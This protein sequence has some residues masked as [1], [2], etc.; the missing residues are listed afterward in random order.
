MQVLG[1]IFSERLEN[2]Y[3]DILKVFP[4]IQVDWE[5]TDLKQMAEKGI[6]TVAYGSFS[7]GRNGGNPKILL[8]ESGLNENTISHELLHLYFF[9]KG[10][11]LG[12]ADELLNDISKRIAPDMNNILHHVL[13]HN[14]QLECGLIIKE[15]LIE[16]MQRFYKSIPE[17]DC[18]EINVDWCRYIKNYIQSELIYFVLYGKFNNLLLPQN[19]T[20]FSVS[21]KI[22]DI[23]KKYDIFTPFGQRR[24]LVFLYKEFD[25]I[26]LQNRC[27]SNIQSYYFVPP[28]LSSRQ[29]MQPFLSVFKYECNDQD[30]KIM[31]YSFYLIVDCQCCY[32]L[33][34]N[35]NDVNEFNQQIKSFT[36][37]DF[38]SS[39]KLEHYI[40]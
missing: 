40:R 27:D 35:K 10:Y 1:Y 12:R 33:D 7:T 2:L 22:L 15:D 36:V 20:I 25:K 5:L 21:H 38:L 4:D 23:I 28:I 3:N 26:L 34:I 8:T 14:K 31:S 37:G 30:F 24:A 9:L 16:E 29:L 19:P 18:K 13:I 32:I 6:D 17:Y 39:Y 11:V